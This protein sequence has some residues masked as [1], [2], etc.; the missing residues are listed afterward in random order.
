M[1]DYIIHP[2][3]RR[4]SQYNDIA[5]LFL[6]EPVTIAENVNTICL[7]QQNDIFDGT[8]CFA[9]GWGKDQFG[10]NGRYQVPEFT[11][12]HTRRES[13][14]FKFDSRYSSS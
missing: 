11:H 1:R 4:G 6:F 13:M 3:Y 2:D 9:S 7:P 14:K 10:A 12:T 5:L 8:V